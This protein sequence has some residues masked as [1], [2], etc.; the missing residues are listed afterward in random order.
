MPVN[1]V[2]MNLV[3]GALAADVITGQTLKADGGASVV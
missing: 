2:G 3:S 1:N